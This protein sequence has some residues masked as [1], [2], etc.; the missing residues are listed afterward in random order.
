VHAS[1]ASIL[2]KDSLMLSLIGLSR[3]FSVQ[4]AL[5]AGKFPASRVVVV[6]PALLLFLA[7]SVV[8]GLLLAFRTDA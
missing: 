8:F 6:L 5:V 2:A 3:F 1:P 4:N 7:I